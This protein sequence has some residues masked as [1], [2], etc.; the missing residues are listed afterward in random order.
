MRDSSLSQST[1]NPFKLGLTQWSHPKWQS[2]FF[3]PGT[4]PQ[5][6]LEKYARVFDT[7]EGNTTFYALPTTNT[8]AQWA[9]ATNDD[10]SFTFKLPK[11]ITHQQQLRQSQSL[12]RDFFTLMA[13]LHSRTIQWCIQ[14]PASFSPQQLPIL[15][16]FC[17]QCP[18]GFPLAVEVRH[19][20]FFAK[21][22][23]EKR[24]NQFLIAHQIDRVIMD[25][26]PVFASQDRDPGTLDAQQKKPRVPVHAIATAKRPMIRFIGQ[27]SVEQNLAFFSPWLK[28]LQQWTQQGIEPLIM[29]HTPDN[30]QAPWHAKAIVQQLASVMSCHPLPEFPAQV[31]RP[32]LNMF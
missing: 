15:E 5:Q 20:A 13:P 21:G 9:R 18:Q 25:S 19:P 3:G 8:V 30:Q 14:L 26:R 12:L 32:Q 27:Q 2:D 28:T 16:K 24:L 17:Q 11:T 23:D 6:R 31:E 29:I 4:P 1:P 7:V 22:E 10:F